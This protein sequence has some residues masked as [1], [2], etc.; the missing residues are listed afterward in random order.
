MHLFERRVNQILLNANNDGDSPGLSDAQLAELKSARFSDLDACGTR[1]VDCAICFNEFG[2]AEDVRLLDCGH[3]YHSVCVDPW[4]K[5]KNTCPIC[6][7][8]ALELST[9]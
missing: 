8:K 6:K 2:A 1:L 4:L 9:S 3:N 5:K 7:C